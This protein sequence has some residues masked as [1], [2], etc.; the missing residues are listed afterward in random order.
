MRAVV[1]DE[2]GGPEVLAVREVEALD[3]GPGE[4]CIRVGA[5][6]VNP[7]DCYVRTG[8]YAFFR[9]E[10]PYT[11]GFDA[12]GTVV[13]LGA[14]VTGWSPGD[15]VYTSALLERRT[16]GTYAEQFVCV[17]SSLRRLPDR[18]SFAAGAAVGVPCGA[19]WRA[20]HQRAEVRAD[21]WVLVHGATGAVGL[22]A[23]Q[24]A[25]AA[26]ARVI[27][28]CG[29]IDG[30]GAQAVREAGAAYVIAHEVVAGGAVGR[31][32]D[33]HGADVVIEMLA[34]RNLMA[35]LDALATY[36]RI[37]VVGS[38]GELPFTPR[39]TMIKEADVLGMALWNATPAEWQAM[40]DGIEEALRAEVLTP[41]IERAYPLAEAAEAHREVIEHRARGKIVLTP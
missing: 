16:H 19:A 12:A 38:R 41:V 22:A 1:M 9:P 40:N 4:V 32:T 17:A 27:G 10:L 34:D 3:P 18:L 36:G 35:D 24:L 31:L 6:G 5:A 21:D 7:A 25:Q 20:V 15:R 2:F 37:V 33:G 23:V 30:P 11:P 39:A 8:T 29:E 13:A 26:G 14:D 28:T